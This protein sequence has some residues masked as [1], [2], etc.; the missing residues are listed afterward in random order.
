MLGDL[1]LA[2]MDGY[3]I[4]PFRLIARRLG[5]ALVYTEFINA[6]DV[7]QRAPSLADRIKFCEEER[8]VVF[9]IYDDNPERLLKAAQIL[10]GYAPD[11]ID[12]NLG[13]PS[14]SV[15][16]RGAGAA[17]LQ[18]PAKIAQIFERL[19]TALSIPVSAK[20]RIGWDEHNLNYLE[21]AKIIEDC[22]GAMLAVHARSKTQSYSGN[23]SWDAIAQVKQSVSIPVIGNGDVRTVQDIEALKSYTGCDAVMIGRAALKNPWIF[24]LR[25]RSEV[26]PEELYHA[27]VWQLQAMVELYGEQRG[28][29]LFRKYLK[30]YLSPCSLPREYMLDI[31]TTQ[32]LS[33][34]FRLLEN[35]FQK[36]AVFA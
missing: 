1:A 30:G 4:S 9:Q 22:G 23:A 34:L 36:P 15:V 35:Y 20:M 26:P 5:A 8:P 32:N 12:V 29:V 7:V 21:V 17:L 19:T 31:L 6:I 13:C 11:W 24:S 2:P 28:V 16:H 14:R 33:E 10:E 25:N 18:S 3:T 27:I